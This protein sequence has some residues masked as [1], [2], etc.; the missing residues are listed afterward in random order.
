MVEPTILRSNEIYN[1]FNPKHLTLDVAIENDIT[2]KYRYTL[3]FKLSNEYI[4]SYEETPE[5]RE[6]K[7]KHYWK[8]KF[9]GIVRHLNF[10]NYLA[11]KARLYK[12]FV[13]DREKRR[14]GRRKL[15]RQ[16]YHLKHQK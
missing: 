16:L 8:E 3:V 12:Q 1:P 9:N 6:A 13:R 14:Y 2:D 15:K 7:L 5:E 4:K 11:E 10:N